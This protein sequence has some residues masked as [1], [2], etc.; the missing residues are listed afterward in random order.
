MNATKVYS[1]FCDYWDNDTET[2]C[3]EWT[4][5]EMTLRDAQATVRARG[6]L[7]RLQLKGGDRCPRHR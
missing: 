4:A 7:I 1:I 2:Q 3:L 6:W 5:Q